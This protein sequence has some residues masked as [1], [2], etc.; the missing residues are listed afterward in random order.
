MKK[1]TRTNAISEAD[2]NYQVKL[3]YHTLSTT[4]PDQYEFNIGAI[5][6]RMRVFCPGASER[7]GGRVG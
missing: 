4:L 7:G 3:F 2:W 5:W 1:G 6:L